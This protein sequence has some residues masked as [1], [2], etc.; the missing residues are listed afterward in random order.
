MWVMTGAETL[1]WAA[2]A[3]LFW[4]KS[5]SHRFQAMCYY[6]TLRAVTGPLVLLLLYE[7][8][9]AGSRAHYIFFA[10]AYGF[11]FFASYLAAAV[12]MFFI[13]IEVV[14]AALL[15]FPGIARLVIVIFRWV[16]VVSVLV[17]LASISYTHLRWKSLPDI[18]YGIE[19]SVSILLI[20]LLAFL[21]L[22]MNALR[23]SARNL[24]FGITLGFGVMA[25][26][27]FVLACWGPHIKS[28]NDPVEFVYESLILVALAIWATYCIL[29]EPAGQPVLV[30]A[31]SAIYRWN[32]IASALGHTGTRVAV[33]RPA[34]SFFLSDVEHVV[35]KV[36]ARNM[37]GRE[38][39]S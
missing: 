1:L 37:E 17:T 7:Q 38:S 35:E 18:L 13:C 36:L 5:I 15:P 28:L 25:S 8:S 16:A 20:C 31:N 29:P 32:E 3:A 4:K 39:E 30:A 12:L 34:N 33:H 2:L 14:R 11:G 21:C 22:S 6:L 9:H 27:D 10:R 26:G 23:L 19:H 24:A